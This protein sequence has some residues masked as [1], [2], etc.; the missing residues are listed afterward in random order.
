LT[1]RIVVDY[2]DAG[3]TEPPPNVKD[4]RVARTKEQEKVLTVPQAGK[5]YL[6]LGTTASYAAARRGEIPV[7]KIGGRL[8]VP[9]AAMEA[10]LESVM[11]KPKK[12]A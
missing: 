10:L 7:L 6:K 2:I 11:P 5:R 8:L 9:T 12:A 1:Y 4:T 3:G